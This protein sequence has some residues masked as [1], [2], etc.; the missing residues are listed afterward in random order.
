MTKAIL[1]LRGMEMTDLLESIGENIKELKE[2]EAVEFILDREEVIHQLEKSD[3]KME[4]RRVGPNYVLK[5]FGGKI[6]IKEKKEEEEFEIDENTNVGKLINRYPEAIEI[7][8]KY[9]FT[10]IKNPVLR[11]TLAKTI[12]L[13]RARKLEG[14]SEEKFKEL[15][16]ELKELKKK[17]KKENK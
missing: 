1:D 7:L 9:G 4:V 12:N 10:P 16:E 17:K 13:G 8:A 2:G 15:L 5:V 3:L 6:E 14:L 11:K